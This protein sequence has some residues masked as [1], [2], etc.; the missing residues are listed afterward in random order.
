MPKGGKKG[1]KIVAE[2]TRFFHPVPGIHALVGCEP[3]QHAVA[4]TQRCK[5]ES[6]PTPHQKNARTKH[7]HDSSKIADARIDRA[8]ERTW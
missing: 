6:K 2:F 1:G 5:S 8:L 4:T 3:H 7:Q